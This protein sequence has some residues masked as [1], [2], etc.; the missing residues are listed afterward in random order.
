MPFAAGAVTPAAEGTKTVLMPLGPPQVKTCPPSSNASR[1]EEVNRTVS[2]CL[3]WSTSVA[4]IRWEF[5]GN[6]LGMVQADLMPSPNGM[7]QQALSHGIPQ[8]LPPG[9]DAPSDRHHH[10]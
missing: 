6:S 8:H 10:R 9:V 5:A 7:A 1:L 2:R 3:R 4:E